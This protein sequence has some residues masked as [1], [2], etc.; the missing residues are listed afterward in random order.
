MPPPDRTERLA[1]RREPPSRSDRSDRAGSTSRRDVDGRQ[2]RRPRSAMAIA[3][4]I[5]STRRRCRSTTRRWCRR[6]RRGRRWPCAARRR[7]CRA[8]GRA[9]RGPC[10]PTRLTSKPMR[11]KSSDASQRR[12]RDRC[13]A[14]GDAGAR[15]ARRRRAD[16]SA[17]ARGGIDAAVLYLTLRV[18]GLQNTLDDLRVLPPVP[19]VGFLAHAGVWL[20]GRVHR[21]RR[22]DHR[23][24]G[25]EPA[26]DWRRRPAGRCRR[27]HAARARLHAGA[28][29]ARP[30]IP[31]RAVHE[32]SSG[33]A[34]SA[35]RARAWSSE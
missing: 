29:H 21:G 24:D 27:R 12:E 7:K 32:R 8:T 19:F 18:T 34:R 28:D 9:R 4:R 2:S 31:A 22:P 20:R 25:A 10:G 15:R 33:A 3:R 23:Q 16:R 1:E 14:D 17:A 6:P 30:V 35:R 26:R 13:V 5:R 11:R